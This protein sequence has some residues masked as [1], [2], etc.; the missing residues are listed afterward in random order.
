MISYQPRRQ[1][2][3]ARYQNEYGYYIH[4]DLSREENSWTDRQTD[5]RTCVWAVYLAGSRPTTALQPRR[6][7]RTYVHPVQISIPLFKKKG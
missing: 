1:E 6:Y 4:N 5:N 2:A 7:V 3:I